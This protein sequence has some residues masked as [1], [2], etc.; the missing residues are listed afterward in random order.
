MLPKVQIEKLVELFGDDKNYIWGDQK[1]CIPKPGV[2]IEFEKG[3]QKVSL[4]IC[5]ECQIVISGDKTKNIGYFDPIHLALVKLTKEI[6]PKD[7]VI[8]KLK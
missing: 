6:F 8:Q 1:K 2:L 4:R 7:E 3:D 5:F